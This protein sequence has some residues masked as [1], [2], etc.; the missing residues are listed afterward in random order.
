MESLKFVD[1]FAGLGGFHLALRKLE[2]ECVFASEID[3]LLR[4][5]Y[6]KNFPEMSGALFGDIRE[7]WDKIPSKFDILCAGFPCQPFSKSGGQLG[8]R[9]A[10]RGTLFHDIV[11][12]LEKWTPSY[13]ILEN[14]GN[15]ERHDRGNTWRVVR[16]QLQR[17]GYNVRA[18]EHRSPQARIDWR[19]RN[20]GP[21]RK[22]FKVGAAAKVGGVGLISPHHFGYPQHRERFFVVASK[23][24]LP[25][26]PFPRRD[27]HSV[28][29]LKDIIQARSELS[30]GDRTETA[31]TDR[32]ER[33]IDHW[34]RLVH[35]IPKSIPMPTFPIWGDELGATYPFEKKTPWATRP[36]VLRQHIRGRNKYRRLRKAGLLK[37]LPSY[38]QERVP[39]FRSW[40]KHYI[41]EN[42]AWW[43]G[44]KRHLPGGWVA[45]L[46]GFPASLRKLEWN[47]GD[48][49]RDLWQYVLQFRPSG[50]RVKRYTSSPALVAMT[51]TQI[52]L[53][54]PEHRFLT[55]AE[56]LRLQRFPPDF[57]IPE[58]REK[59][60]QAL[61]N[62]VHVDVARN[63]AKS[64]LSPSRG[65][66]EVERDPTPSD[67]TGMMAEHVA[68]ST[69]G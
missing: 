24:W 10:T 27:R 26:D 11:R 61:G 50:L 57:H 22:R 4:E 51:A 34:N 23:D 64:L 62:A 39:E 46:R 25:L 38:A 17:L 53:L 67:G 48:G 37:E 65:M 60:F 31:L 44:V 20:G 56:G 45:E 68:R 63:I 59:T 8:T 9:D 3:P 5:I 47:V 6:L 15:F 18:T 69:S 13:V 66:F 32:Q 29:S 28:T 1:L 40:K 54:G 52:P 42:R 41:R 21:N 55:R 12:V 58:S 49:E 2:H 14:V 7:S 33:N 30:S 35:A 19:D 43:Y 16:A 36:I